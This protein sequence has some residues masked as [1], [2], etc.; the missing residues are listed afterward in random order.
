[1]V[2]MSIVMEMLHANELGVQWTTIRHKQHCMWWCKAALSRVHMVWQQ[3]GPVTYC[4][5]LSTYKDVLMNIDCAWDSKRSK[6]SSWIELLFIIM[7]TIHI[8]TDQSSW[9]TMLDSIVSEQFQTIYVAQYSWNII[10][11]CKEIWSKSHW[12]QMGHSEDDHVTLIGGTGWSRDVDR[13]YG[14]ITWCCTVIS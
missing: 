11:A 6:I 9:I 14:M 12:A 8:R 1:M 10:T 3:S 5:W 2:F 13:W 4:W 7:I